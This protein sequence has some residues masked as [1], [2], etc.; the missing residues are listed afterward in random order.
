MHAGINRYNPTRHVRLIVVVA[1]LLLAMLPQALA[2]GPAEL[3]ASPQTSGSTTHVVQAGETL[4]IIAARY[5]VTVQEIVSTNNIANANIIYVGQRLQIPSTGQQQPGAAQPAPAQP[6]GC[7][8]THTVVAGESLSGLAV[9]YGVTIQ[10]LASA[11][12]TTVTSFVYIGQRLCIPGAGSGGGTTGGGGTPTR[13]GGVWY[14]VQIGDT[15]SRIA[16]NHGVTVNA[17]VQANNLPNP[18]TVILGH[19]NLDSAG[20]VDRACAG[21]TAACACARAGPGNRRSVRSRDHFGQA[22]RQGRPRHRVSRGIHDCFRDACQNRR[23][24]PQ[25]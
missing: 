25:R 22:K 6:G 5:G 1:V 14:E 10:S 9:R 3:N 23:Y 16:F 13:S 12:N 17:I 19:A 11:N 24:W 7:A 21:G 4:A 15:L 2:A 18:N 8:Q 20:R